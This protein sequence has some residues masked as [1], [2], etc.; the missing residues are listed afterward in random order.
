MKGAPIHLIAE[1]G[2]NHNAS[3]ATGKALIRHAADAGADSVKFQMIFPAGLYLPVERTG[4]GRLIPSPVFTKREATALRPDDYRAL[5]DYCSDVG[6][7][8]SASVFDEQGIALLDELDAPYIK[9]ASCDLNNSPLIER[10]A[11]TGR[12]LVISTGMAQLDEIERAVGDARRAG[13][14]DLVLMHCVSVYPCPVE[15]ANVSFVDVLRERF[16]GPV[17][18]SDHTESSVAAV[19]AIAR[20]ARWIEKHITLDRTHEGFDHAYAMEPDGFAAYAA[21]LSDAWRAYAPA[22]TKVGESEQV[23]RR[24]ARRGLYA[25][26][27]IRAGERI[28][29]EAVLCVRPQAVLGPNAIGRVLDRVATRDIEAY[30]PFAPDMVTGCSRAAIING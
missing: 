24:R 29:Q 19:V 28:E 3:V 16:D 2:T 27:R 10:A 11:A 26:R 13:A 12:T 18:Y 14:D 9:I 23:V 21:D 5:A 22:A 1:A 20:G 25:S 6:V 4:D 17:G 30:E 15:R 8:F 7:G